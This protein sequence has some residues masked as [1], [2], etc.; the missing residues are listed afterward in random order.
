MKDNFNKTDSLYLIIDQSM[1]ISKETCTEQIERAREILQN[2][3]LVA[4]QK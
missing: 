3:N 4:Q 1:K 2:Y